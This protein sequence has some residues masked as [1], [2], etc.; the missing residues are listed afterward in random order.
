MATIHRSITLGRQKG[1]FQGAFLAMGSPCEVLCG[2]TDESLAGKLLDALAGEAWRIEDKFS[3]YLPDNIVDRINRGD[4]KPVEVDE[5]TA[6]LLDFATSLHELSN[7]R[8]DITSGVLRKAWVFDG[9]DKVP[10]DSLVQSILHTVGWDKVLWER[11]ILTMQAGMQIDFGGIG[12]EYAVDKAAGLAREGTGSPLLLNFGGDIVAT[13]PPESSS[14]WQ[15]GIEALDTSVRKA[16]RVIRLSQGALATSGDA[17]RF[18]LKDGTRYGH[19]LDPTTGWPVADAPRSITVAA[20][21]CTQAG[22]LA[23]LAMLQGADAEEFL[24]EQEIQF[25]CQR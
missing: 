7:G 9:S 11:P 14:G 5:E 1:H 21:T 3:R 17:R 15:V 22:M 25:W 10:E 16:D 12:K 4:G 19:I 2:T 13:G 6:N 20:D 23:T 18:V 8:F 24:R